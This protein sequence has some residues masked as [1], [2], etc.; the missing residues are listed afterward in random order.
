MELQELTA[1]VLA[2]ENISV[3]KKRVHTASFDLVNRVLTLPQWDS[4]DPSVESMLVM[5][6]VAHALFTPSKEYVDAADKHKYMR[7]Y[8]NVL[9]DARIE[10]LMKE[11]YPGGRKTFTNAYK[12]LRDTDFFEL[13]NRDLSTM[14]FVDRINLYF[15]LGV[16]CGVKFSPDEHQFVLR[17]SNTVTFD[18][19]LDLAQDIYNFVKQKKEES[20][21]ELKDID[22]IGGEGE[23]FFGDIEETDDDSGEGEYDDSD[24]E[25][26]EEG[27]D[28]SGEE[29]SQSNQ[30]SQ[31]RANLQEEH[32]SVTD[33]LL[34][35]KLEEAA[36]TDDINTYNF[37][38][39][40]DERLMI[41]FKEILANCRNNSVHRDTLS[42]ETE[43]YN[44]FRAL[45][46]KQVN[47]LVQMFELKKAAEVYVRRRITKTGML[48]V[49]K[50]SQ[51][52]IKDDLFR[53]AIIVPEGQNHG[54]VMLIDWSKSMINGNNIH[55]CIRQVIQLVMFCNKLNIPFRVFAFANN[56]YDFSGVN[57]DR[58]PYSYNGQ[59]QVS[60]L[61]LF[62]NKMTLKEMKEMMTFA[63]GF[64][65]LQTYKLTYTPLSPALLAM[66]KVIPEFMAEHNVKKLNFVTF[67]DG[68]CTSP[69]VN[70]Y[71]TSYIFDNQTKKNYLV[72]RRDNSRMSRINEVR[73]I[74]SVNCLYNIIK[75]RYNATVT[76]FFVK[77]G[78][79]IDC[80]KMSGMYDADANNI[81]G[82][83][84][85]YKKNGF[86]KMSG[87]GRDAIYIVNP[88]ILR[89]T[90]F[91]IS[92]IDENMSPSAIARNIKNGSKTSIKGKILIEKL[93]E[94][95]S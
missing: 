93:S 72:Y 14:R 27:G 94:T 40:Y 3:Y 79:L 47:H 10:R 20:S 84:G 89:T 39:E 70:S 43:Q 34:K 63:C 86:I 56:K 88:D 71:S 69:L 12:N 67:T 68:G 33:N 53:R 8:L 52:K 13:G 65:L 32:E 19:V 54:L 58:G 2:T 57:I 90:E 73:P 60:L 31:I 45:S 77:N 49:N 36:G 42:I 64:S 59:D 85:E 37:S 66:R 81:A 74:N 48:D 75:D 44:K 21:Q 9:E 41:P 76:T 83:A 95:L 17:A 82:Y 7:S 92:N 25:E 87:F 30:Y 22:N 5:H 4:L 16:L 38:E 46:T 91:A 6:E 26:F 23:D 29:E 11:R 28:D 62:S 61:E 80:L 24:G 50:I 1:K 55:H 18:E 15:K 35:S 51:Y 78:N